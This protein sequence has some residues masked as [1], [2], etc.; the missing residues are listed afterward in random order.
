MAQ[1]L[2][3]CSKKLCDLTEDL[4]IHRQTGPSPQGKGKSSTGGAG[5]V[6]G[7]ERKSLGRTGGWGDTAF[8]EEGQLSWA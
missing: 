2:E 4:R 8:T 1:A 5:R 7:A 3:T 6:C